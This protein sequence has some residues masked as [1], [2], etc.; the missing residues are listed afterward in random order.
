MPRHRKEAGVLASVANLRRVYYQQTLIAG[1]T[2]I[3]GTVDVVSTRDAVFLAE[4][5]PVVEDGGVDQ[6]VT[7]QQPVY[8]VHVT[9]SITAQSH[10]RVDDGADHFIT[11]NNDHG[12]RRSKLPSSGQYLPGRN[13]SFLRRVLIARQHTDALY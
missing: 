5:V 11:C 2:V 3:A 10:C 7:I 13:R 4:Q 8:H 1:L 12:I 6:G 9:A